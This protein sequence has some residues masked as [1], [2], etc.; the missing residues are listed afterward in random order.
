MRR[1]VCIGY[2]RGLERL[3][4]FRFFVGP[5]WNADRRLIKPI[6]HIEIVCDQRL[7]VI[8]LSCDQPGYDFVIASKE[9]QNE[10]RHRTRQ[11]VVCSCSCGFKRTLSLEA[12]VPQ[13]FAA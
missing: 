6:W 9:E 3:V 5:M 10:G 11:A 7:S 1:V 12:N 4:V 2:W 13:V 8:K